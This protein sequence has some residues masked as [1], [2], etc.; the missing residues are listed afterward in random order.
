MT[1][2]IVL[3]VLA[4]LLCISMSVCVFANST[5]PDALFV[6]DGADLLT[7]N[8]EAQLRTRLEEISKAY[9]A[10]V[11]VG[12][13]SQMN[14]SDVDSFTEYVYDSTGYG[15]GGD[16]AGVLLLICMDV[17][18]Y[19][20]LSNGFAA[21]AITPDYIDS[22]SDAIVS[23]LSDGDYADA[24]HRYAEE[25]EYY[26]NGYLNGF[27]FDLEGTL[28]TSVLIGLV[29][30][31]VV[32]LVLKGQLKSVRK[33]QNA[34]L[35]VKQGSMH[36]TQVGDYFMYRNVTRTPRQTSDSSGSSSRSS[37]SSRNI[38]GGKF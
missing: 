38:G 14:G 31:A 36:L 1:K 20:I 15:Y 37:G 30:G 35:Y 9:G 29:V 28:L 3:L 26:L 8:E 32:A 5:N 12:T 2:K 25:C 21:D 13:V 7:E 6:I 33:N 10:Q 19:R 18:E 27:P 34:N 17:R 16:K 11:A 24:F 23:D 22:I 4:L